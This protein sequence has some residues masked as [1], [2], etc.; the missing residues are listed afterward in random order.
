MACSCFEFSDNIKNLSTAKLNMIN[1]NNLFDTSLDKQEKEFFYQENGI[2]QDI[3]HNDMRRIG[4][5]GKKRTLLNCLGA[6]A[7]SSSIDSGISSAVRDS[8]KLSMTK[9]MHES[10]METTITAEKD[11]SFKRNNTDLQPKNVFLNGKFVTFH[12]RR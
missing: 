5:Q 1:V 11:T 6:S 3:G 9:I 2:K 4:Y 12:Q 8:S 10:R 7:S